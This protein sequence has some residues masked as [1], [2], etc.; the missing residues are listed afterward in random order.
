MSAQIS[1]FARCANY[2]YPGLMWL[3]KKKKSTPI[4]QS[5]KSFC[6]FTVYQ[7]VCNQLCLCLQTSFHICMYPH[8]HVHVCVLHMH[9]QI[10][11]NHK[12]SCL[13]DAKSLVSR[14]WPRVVAWAR[15]QL[16]KLN[17]LWANLGWVHQVAS[18]HTSHIYANWESR[19]GPRPSSASENPSNRM[20]SSLLCLLK[21][22]I[23]TV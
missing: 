14:A 5:A 6:V 12:L 20:T 7:H 13:P 22:A 18:F 9:I 15:C 17:G 4:Y 2:E 1:H 21:I 16:N 19:Q 10:S 8:T 3:K 23:A 11:A